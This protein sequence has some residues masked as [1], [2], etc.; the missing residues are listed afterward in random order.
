MGI[1]GYYYG[2]W[3]DEDGSATRPNYLNHLIPNTFSLYAFLSLF[4]SV[5]FILV[6]S[7]NQ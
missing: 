3:L 2:V 1:M 6:S 5:R 4:T 7:V